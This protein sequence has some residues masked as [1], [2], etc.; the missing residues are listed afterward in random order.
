MELYGALPCP[1]VAAEDWRNWRGAMARRLR[2]RATYQIR[3]LKVNNRSAKGAGHVRISG[4][5]CRRGDDL[6]RRDGLQ[7]DNTMAWITIR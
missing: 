6:A 2:G 3:E 7:P 5:S 4:N 1:L